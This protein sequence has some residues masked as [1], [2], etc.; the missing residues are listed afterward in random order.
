MHGNQR[1]YPH[2]N[3]LEKMSREK[4]PLQKVSQVKMSLNKLAYRANVP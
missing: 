4:C 1:K 2:K 3:V